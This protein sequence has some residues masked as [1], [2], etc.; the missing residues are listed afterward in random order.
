MSSQSVIVHCQT[1]SV[2]PN[3][4]QHPGPYSQTGSHHCLAQDM[5]SSHLGH[6]VWR[7]Y[8]LGLCPASNS[9][10]AAQDRDTGYAQ[11][12]RTRQTRAFVVCFLEAAWLN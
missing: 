1:R 9:H 5:K 12:R 3:F 7:D 10:I 2:C 11:R 4:H 6:W 8:P